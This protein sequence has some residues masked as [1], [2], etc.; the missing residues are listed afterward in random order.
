MI[1]GV[2][3]LGWK[4]TFE[5][6]TFVD[7]RGPDA[8]GQVIIA[9]PEGLR[10]A[11]FVERGRICWAGAQGLARRLGE[12]LRAGDR[13]EALLQHTLESIELLHAGGVKSTWHPRKGRG[14]EPRFTFGTAELL[15]RHGAR[16]VVNDMK[17]EVAE[18]AA[19]A[20]RQA[21]GEAIVA[22]GSIT[23]PK[24]PD[25]LAKTAVDKFGGLDIIVNNAGYTHDGVIHKMSDEQWTAMLDVHLTGPFRL[26]RAASLYW[27]EWAKSFC[28]AG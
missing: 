6:C 17:E 8:V 20:I 27:R 16:V 18:E 4:S 12:L 22:A 14:F 3:P 5:A 2:P 10:G 21:G 7:A 28:F 15:A 13:R 24:F 9:G 25:R 19:T 23:D 26:L 11:I 1:A